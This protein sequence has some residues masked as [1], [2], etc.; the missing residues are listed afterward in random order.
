KD[1]DALET[2]RFHAHLS[3]V[4]ETVQR[5][6][7]ELPAGAA[8][9]GFCGAPW[10]VATYMIAG[11]G[12]PDQAPARLFGYAHPQAFNRLLDILAAC[13][14]EYL[15]RQ[16]DAGADAVQI[17]DSWAGVLDD[18]AFRNW[19]IRPTAEIVRR[20]REKHPQVP[21]I[22]FPRGAGINYAR[23]RSE[24][25]V[26][27]L[28]LDWTVPLPEAKKLQSQGPV[29]G[30]LDPMRLLA[31]GRALSEGVNAILQALGNGP[32]VFNL[33]HGI[34]PDTPISH[35]EAMIGQVRGAAG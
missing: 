15:I 29:Q 16:I 6:R 11:R 14:A 34:T 18:A 28:G 13:S 26:S 31:G 9:I 8:L 10:T 21:I 24:T 22:G 25:D 32:L 4:Y 3:P 20:V 30:N 27:A 7:R 33:G 23:Y 1:I 2:G 17:F 12:T 5:L 35:V 19:C